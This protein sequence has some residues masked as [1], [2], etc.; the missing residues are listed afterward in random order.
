MCNSYTD[1]VRLATTIR[2]E[3]ETAELLRKLG[4]K[5]ETYDEIIRRLVAR[6]FLEELDERFERGEFVPAEKVPWDRLYQLNED[7]LDELLESL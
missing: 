7:E 6:D 2:V 3:R 4:R 1:G 5:G